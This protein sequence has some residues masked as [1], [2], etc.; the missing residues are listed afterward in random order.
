MEKPHRKLK[1][2]PNVKRYFKDLLY[3]KDVK[4]H[5]DIGNNFSPKDIGRKL[6]DIGD[7]IY[8]H[9]KDYKQSNN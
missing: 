7:R 4:S 5:V 3:S 6:A 9:Y 8:F 2:L 1:S